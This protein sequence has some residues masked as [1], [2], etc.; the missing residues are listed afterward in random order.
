[1]WLTYIEWRSALKKE[2]KKL[3]KQILWRKSEKFQAM[4]N[5]SQYMYY[6]TLKKKKFKNKIKVHKFIKY[7]T[8]M[9]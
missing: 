4:I 9:K 3:W 1:M 8:L 5:F 7:I 2:G 6:L